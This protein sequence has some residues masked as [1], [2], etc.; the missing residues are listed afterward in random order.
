VSGN[1]D[2]P[3]LRRL[4]ARLFLRRGRT[5]VFLAACLAVGIAFLSAV[6]HLL[7]AVDVAI[8]A[9]ARDMLTGD[10]QAGSPRPFSAAEDAAFAA[11][12]TPGRRA[13]RSVSLASML[14]PARGSEPPF[15]VSVKA[16]DDAYPL[17]GILKTYP[18]GVKP[19][20]GEALIERSAALQ[21]ALKLGDTMRL[22]NTRLLLSAFIEE[23]PDRDFLGFSFAP[24]LMVS[25]EDLDRAG[26][27]GLG[28]RVRYAWTLALADGED[29]STAARAA[30][31]SLSRALADAHVSLITY[32]EGE[33]SA[34]EG[35]R[36]AALFFTALA[37]AAL[38][39]GAAGLRAGLSLFLDAEAETMGLLRCLGASTAEVE[40]LYAGV[41]VGVGLLGGG[42]G[43]LAGWALAAAAAHEAG[44]LGLALSAPPRWEAFAEALLLSGALAWGLSAAR[45]RA[46]ASR[47]PLDALRA[48]APAPRA[49][50]VA[51]WGAAALAV[52][53]AAWRRA[54]TTKDALLLTA[55]LAGGALVVEVLSR[56]GLAGLERLSRALAA[57]GLPFPARHGLRRLVRR[58]RESRVMLFT[59]AGG[60]ALL[61]AVGAAREGF[62]RAL[63]PS[64]SEDA[65]DLF[66]VDVQPAQVARARALA[67]K[68]ARG[69]ADFAPLVRARLLRVNGEGLK[70]EKPR[71]GEEG[72]RGRWRAREYN[73]TYADALNTSEELVAGK[74]WT[75]GSAA[76][77]ASLER[78]FMDRAGL[79]LGARLTFDVQGREVDAVATSVRRVEWAAM[80][81][82][83]FVTLT[84]NLLKDAPQTF[85][86]SLRARDPAASADLRR[87]LARELPN[88]SV[89]DAAAL[90][91]TAR[92]TLGLILTAVGALAAFCVGV[93][94]LVV[95]GL[96]ALGR[97]ERAQEN[98]LER[99]L[100][101][102]ERESLAADAAELLGL[103]ALSA[104]CAA[105]AGAGLSWALARRLDV[106]LAADP[107]EAAAL[108]LGAFLLPA[109]AGLLAGS[110][111]RRRRT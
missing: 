20:P 4:A 81:P 70:R 88:V 87:A 78:D 86:A 60:F 89:I 26:L 42:A 27:L 84:P 53:F 17:R 65:P 52:C 73:L 46:L 76:A 61:A 48:P 102:T 66:L 2:G 63:A 50:A 36:R 91:A 10:V 71:E 15:L 77:E 58:R 55:A 19:K 109:L 79:K 32:E 43:A 1:L 85:I 82:N 93:G 33:S 40:R 35:L 100:G 94:A 39:L 16:V 13:S 34:R 99:A 72:E 47:P 97:G 98:S 104:A 23:E 106:P 54:P 105:A 6:S 51:G 7:Y 11:A 44:R 90:L 45:V 103:G 24:R 101:W 59:L 68:F 49:L 75:P 41:C 56:A 64:Q 80:R 3:A 25:R 111:A 37:L 8:A 57:T 21:H 92:R 29:A 107:A 96:V 95:A 9:R 67:Q 12:V 31:R 69:A 30:E 38:L 74:F 22:G 110:A 28:A 18:P 108:L 14:T 62:A 83:F 5:M